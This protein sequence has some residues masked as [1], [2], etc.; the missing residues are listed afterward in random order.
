MEKE[1]VKLL[2]VLRRISRA[3]GYAARL[4]PLLALPLPDGR[5]SG[6]QIEGSIKGEGAVMQMRPRLAALLRDGS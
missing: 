6:K 3:A 4:I 2:N 5:A 1:T